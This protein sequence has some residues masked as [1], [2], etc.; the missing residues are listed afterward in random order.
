MVSQASK[1]HKVDNLKNFVY[2]KEA[3]KGVTV[4]IFDDGA[5]KE[6]DVSVLCF[7]D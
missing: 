5:N 4:Y 6:H 1:E 3:G 7:I 2:R